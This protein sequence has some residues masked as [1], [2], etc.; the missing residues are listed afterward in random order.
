M[1]SSVFPVASDA[2]NPTIVDVKGDLIAATAAD[3]VSRLAVGANGTSLVADSTTATGLAYALSPGFAAGKNA[4]INGDFNIWQRGTSFSNPNGVYT[5]DRFRYVGDSTVTLSRQTFTPGTAPVAGYEGTFFLRVAKSAGGSAMVLDQPIEDV[6]KFAG[7]TVTMSFY[8]KADANVTSQAWWDQYFGSGGSGG[9]GTGLAPYFA[10]TTAWQR[11]SYTF[12]VP[13]ISGK[14]IGTSSFAAPQFI[15]I[16]DALAHTIDIWGVQLEAGSVA[17]PFQTATGTLAG[18]L[19]A[20]Q[21][22]LYKF[23]PAT[24]N[25]YERF[26]IVFR[27]GSNFVMLQVPVPMRVYPTSLVTS[28]NFAAF[29]ANHYNMTN[30]AITTTPGGSLNTIILNGT[31][32]GGSTVCMFEFEGN[33]SG[34]LILSAEL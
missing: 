13:S 4:I 6:R 14:T 7:Q 1:A 33:P 21:R 28:G 15:R 34:F 29:D 3:A 27:M 24:G 32:S 30:L 17:T 19:A 22:Y 23:T 9:V 2:I 31:L 16:T 12:N 20:C 8:A 10:I 26:G 5:A 18:E 25:G 11:F